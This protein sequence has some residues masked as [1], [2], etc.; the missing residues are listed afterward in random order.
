MTK[1]PVRDGG[2]YRQKKVRGTSTWKAAE[3]PRPS[4]WSESID[5]F[6]DAETLRMTESHEWDQP[7]LRGL[8]TERV[9]LRDHT[10]QKFK[11]FSSKFGSVAD[12]MKKLNIPLDSNITLDQFTEKIKERNYDIYYSREDQRLLFEKLSRDPADGSIEVKQLVTA[13]G[14]KPVLSDTIPKDVQESSSLDNIRHKVFMQL[15]EKRSAHG[16]ELD[17]KSVS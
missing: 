2:R 4:W 12:M 3:P 15:K 5:K 1:G 7:P 8:E 16:Q 6:R 9:I 17:R 11:K 13:M 14:E 10:I